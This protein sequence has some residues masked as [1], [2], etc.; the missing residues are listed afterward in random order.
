MA[1]KFVK[2]VL[3]GAIGRVAGTFVT[4]R[5]MGFFS[6]FQN[7]RARQFEREIVTEQPVTG[8]PTRT[9]PEWREVS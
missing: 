7:E 1:R 6:R 8:I 4:G 2:D 3:F 5:A 9:R